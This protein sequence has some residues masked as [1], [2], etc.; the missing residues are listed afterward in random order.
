MSIVIIKPGLLDT[1]QDLGRI[2]QGRYGI[3]PGGAMDRY[4]AKMAN[5]LTGNEIHEAVIEIHFP[6]PQILFEKD[7]LVCI[8]GG[9]FVPTVNDDPIPSWQPVLIRKN[10]VLQFSLKNNGARVYLSVAGGFM[11]DKWLNSYSTNLKAAI[12][13][14]QG[15]KLEKNDQLQFCPARKNPS[16]LFRTEDNFEPLRWRPAFQKVYGNPSEICFIKGNE[17]KE[18]DTVS[19]EELTQG[20]FTIQALSDRMGYQLNGHPVTLECRKEFISSAVSFG[21]IQLLPNGQLVILMADHQTTGGYSRIG[22]VISAHLP[23][24]AQLN[25]GSSFHLVPVEMDVAEQLLISQHQELKL[26]QKA[27]LENLNR[28]YV[29]CG[30]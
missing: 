25:A 20:S 2:G 8:T 3:N 13:G 1:I 12:G 21:T 28:L 24:L 26:V 22:H 29:K 10:T 23:K 9:D 4:A 14:W 7:A 6:G 30:Y 17:W 5:I 16:V 27:S 19:R 11:I 18:L 15:R